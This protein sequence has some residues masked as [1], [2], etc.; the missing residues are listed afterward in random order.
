MIKKIR[1][2]LTF[3]AKVNKKME[4]WIEKISRGFLE[5]AK[6]CTKFYFNQIF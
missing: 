3:V 5:I 4:K 6:S 1:F 2:V